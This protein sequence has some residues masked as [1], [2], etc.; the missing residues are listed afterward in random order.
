MKSK[1]GIAALILSIISLVGVSFFHFVLGFFIDL[2]NFEYI[3]THFAETA[4]VGFWITAP[5]LFLGALAYFAIAILL[6]LISIPLGIYST[7]KHPKQNQAK[8]AIL[9]QLI[10]IG[11]VYL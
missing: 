8:I 4:I 11:I 9:L 2:V 3:Q 6:P 5:L 10:A 1:S 7:V